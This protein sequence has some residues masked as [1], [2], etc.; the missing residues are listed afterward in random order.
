VNYRSP[1]SQ[2]EAAANFARSAA[3]PRPG[4]NPG[5][6]GSSDFQALPN[7]ANSAS[8]VFYKLSSQ[9]AST[10]QPA[11]LT[12]YEWLLWTPGVLPPQPVAADVAWLAMHHLRVFSNQSY[13]RLFAFDR[14]RVVHRL[15][16]F[17]KW[18]RYPF[19]A[20]A[21]VQIGNVWTDDTHRGRGLATAGIKKAVAALASSDRSFWYVTT[22]DNLA[23]RA[24]AEHSGFEQFGWGERTERFG[25][26]LLG[27]FEI[28]RHEP[29]PEF[30]H[31]P[32]LMDSAVVTRPQ[33][34]KVPVDLLETALKGTGAVDAP[35]L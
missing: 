11:E 21:D 30:Q 28:K 35:R 31:P 33:A 13:C 23:S 10:V 20:S 2:F 18:M 27:A 34:T 12:R 26:R 9:L 22:K 14:G 3:V 8:Y 1:N 16:V 4:F 29:L 5:S 6:A 15:T 24:A 25:L 7:N 32:F 17:P 19:M